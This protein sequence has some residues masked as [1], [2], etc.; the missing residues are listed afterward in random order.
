M[1]FAAEQARR[2]AE[3]EKLNDDKRAELESERTAR[4]SDRR[5]TR[6]ARRALRKE[7]GR[8]FGRGY[9]SWGAGDE[10]DPDC[11]ETKDGTEHS[12][13]DASDEA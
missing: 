13:K 1:L 10:G 2:L 5:T 4:K 11:K 12:D 6:E 9:G 8:R 3:F 7:E